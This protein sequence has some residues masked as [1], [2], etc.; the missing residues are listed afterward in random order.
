MAPSLKKLYEEIKEIK[1]EMKRMAHVINEDFELSDLAKKEL[2]A[3]RK[4]PASKYVDHAEVV[5]E[6]S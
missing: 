1:I 6:F 4:I 2:E 3:A 5:K